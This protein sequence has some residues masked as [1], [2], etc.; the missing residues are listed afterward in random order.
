VQSVA[1]GEQKC[2]KGAVAA[3]EQKML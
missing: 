3:E 2:L 1:A